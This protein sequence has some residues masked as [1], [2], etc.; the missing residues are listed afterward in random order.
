[1]KNKKR[2]RKTKILIALLLL[3]FMGVLFSTSVYAWFTANKTVSIEQLDVNVGAGSGLQLSVDAI[4]WK[5][6]ITQDDI[7]NAQSTY[8][9]VVN[10]IPDSAIYPVS[11]GGVIDPNTGY[12]NMYKGLVDTYG[13]H[14]VLQ[15]TKST[16]TADKS[17]DFIVFDLFIKITDDA[18]VSLTTASKVISD[19]SK[20]LE[21]AARVAFVY[22]GEGDLATSATDAQEFIAS[23]DSPVYIWEPNADAHTGAAKKHAMDTYGIDTTNQ[24]SIKYNGVIGEFSK[25]DD[26]LLNTTPETEGNGKYFKAMSSIVYTP[27]NNESETEYFSLNSG[28]TKFRV[29]IWVEGQDVDCENDASGS[30][31]SYNIQ[32]SMPNDIA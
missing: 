5:P 20:G 2:R 12:L 31:V 15:S 29:Y 28:V 17:G 4:N 3:L 22:Q 18:A 30:K 26:V 1:M 14:Y 19:N 11:T 9:G 7:K 16:E 24:A 10:H 8:S 21:N 6:L 13:D 32:L 25:D 27:V 23:A